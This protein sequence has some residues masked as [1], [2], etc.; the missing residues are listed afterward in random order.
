MTCN[1]LR[2][3][4]VV[5]LTYDY[6]LY[7]GLKCLEANSYDPQLSDHYALTAKFAV[8]EEKS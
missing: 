3:K 2:Y 7:K 1:N 8:I 6:I 5:G 4:V